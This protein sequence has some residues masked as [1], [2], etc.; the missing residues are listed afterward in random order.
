MAQASRVTI[1]VTAVMMAA[2][3]LAP[4]AAHAD[5]LQTQKNNWRN[6]AIGAGAVTLY[7]L[8]NHQNT[9]TLLGAAG[10]AYSLSQYERKRHEQSQRRAARARWHRHHRYHHHR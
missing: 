6:G 5:K 10:T 7:G 8:K 1:A 9:T 3:V 4:L 2:S